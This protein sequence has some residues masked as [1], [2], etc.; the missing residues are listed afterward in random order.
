M[1]RISILFALYSVQHLADQKEG[2]CCS[3]KLT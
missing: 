3:Y 1:N 2:G